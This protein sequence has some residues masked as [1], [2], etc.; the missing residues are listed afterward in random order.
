MTDV[1]KLRRGTLVRALSTID[2]EGARVLRGEFGVVF[3]EAGYHEPNTGPMVRWFSGG[4]CNVYD[5]DVEVV[6]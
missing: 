1:M 5:D 3:E 6:R 4:A 2:P